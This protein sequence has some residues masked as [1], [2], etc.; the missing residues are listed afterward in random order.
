M[1]KI[2]SKKVDLHFRLQVIGFMGVIWGVKNRNIWV[3][4][5][6]LLKKV[7]HNWEWTELEFQG[8]CWSLLKQSKAGALAIRT[9]S[10]GDRKVIFKSKCSLTWEQIVC[11]VTKERGAEDAALG[12]YLDRWA[13]RGITN[14]YRKTVIPWGGKYWQGWQGGVKKMSFSWCILNSIFLWEI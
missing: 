5:R 1:T 8:T 2:H 6:M 14:Q 10:K 13:D 11:I 3:L 9:K 7:E 4:E 12:S